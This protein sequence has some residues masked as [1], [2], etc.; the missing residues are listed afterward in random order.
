MTVCA[1]VPESDT[2][3]GEFTALLTIETLPVTAPYVPGVNVALNEVFCPAASM[4][5]TDSPLMLNALPLTLVW[6]IVALA[7]PVLLK[8]RG[9]VLLLPNATL[10]KLTLFG[11]EA[12][13]AVAAAGVV[14]EA[15][16]EYELR[17]PAASVARTR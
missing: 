17:F 5:G 14:E 11:F 16:L 13:E 8:T 7:L 9:A 2:L 1:P 4:N 10:P 3:N 6:D 15:T 12:S